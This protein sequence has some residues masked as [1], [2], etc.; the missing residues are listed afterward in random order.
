VKPLVITDADGA[1]R[2]AAVTDEK[3]YRKSV[4]Q[5]ELW[6]LN[7]ETGRLLPQAGGHRLVSISDEGGWYRAVVDAPGGSSDAAV[8]ESVGAANAT[9]PDTSSARP[10]AGEDV[11]SRLSEVVRRRQGEM[12]EGSYTSYLFSSGLDKIR[13]KTGEEAV[14]LVL[15]RE[16]AEV[17]SESADLLYHLLVLLRAQGIETDEVLE[18]LA[19][20]LD[21]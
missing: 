3:G 16:R 10:G 19:S 20:R 8:Q 2:A 14:E 13:K 15:A 7:P 12:P 18:E 21:G 9:P 6:T 5:G 11:L 1:V 4:E 17:V